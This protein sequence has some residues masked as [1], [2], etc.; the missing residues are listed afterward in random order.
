MTIPQNILQ[1][2]INLKAQMESQTVAAQGELAKRTDIFKGWLDQT[3]A[4]QVILTGDAGEANRKSIVDAVFGEANNPRK[5]EWDA[6]MRYSDQWAAL[7]AGA[8][9]LV[10][11]PEVAGIRDRWTGIVRAA[12]EAKKN[13]GIARDANTLVMIC[14]PSPKSDA[15]K[16]IDKHK[17]LVKQVKALE[18]YY[19]GA[20]ALAAQLEALQFKPAAPAPAPVV[21]PAT[22]A[23]PVAPAAPV[24]AT[25]FN[26]NDLMAQIGPALAAMVDQAVKARG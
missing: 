18:A 3:A 20:M 5:S 19:P 4:A 25:G 17:T 26:V 21:A 7:D 10:A 13:S 23:T 22:P 2:A 8:A 15:E 14:R 12:R 6:L 11:D 9:A 1:S 24:G 16:A